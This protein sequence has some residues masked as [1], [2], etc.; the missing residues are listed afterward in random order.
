M[1]NAIICDDSQLCAELAGEQVG[2]A[3]YDIY[4]G[5]PDSR[6]ILES[7][8]FALIADISPL[9]EG[10]T[11][12]VPKMHY[13]SFGRVPPKLWSELQVFSGKCIDLISTKYSVPTVLEHGSS[14]SM[15]SSPCISHA[16]W[17]IVPGAEHVV[18]VFEADG[19]RGQ[20]VLSWTELHAFSEKDYSYIYYRFQSDQIAYVEQLSKRHQY[21]R[22][23]M[24]EV[25]SIPEPEWDWALS[26][27]PDLLRRTIRNLKA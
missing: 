1:T 12:L 15:R 9:V 26:L 17:H 24:A 23:A 7:S 6:V 25:F 13:I 16:H 18:Q 19:L 3:F 22:I 10:H 11:M 4:H 21:L 5:D 2:V 27:R 20:R 8:N 14:Q